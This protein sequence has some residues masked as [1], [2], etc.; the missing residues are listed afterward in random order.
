MLL[1]I[2]TGG[3]CEVPPVLEQLV[4]HIPDMVVYR[5]HNAP[6]PQTIHSYGVVMFA[7]I[8]GTNTQA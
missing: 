8:S 5:A 3:G 1:D 7:D 4:T 6:M 2:A